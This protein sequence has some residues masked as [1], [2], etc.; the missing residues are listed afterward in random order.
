M[1]EQKVI[2]CKKYSIVFNQSPFQ[3]GFCGNFKNM[4]TVVTRFV[5]RLCNKCAEDDVLPDFRCSID[6]KGKSKHCAVLAGGG[7]F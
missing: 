1:S 3:S 7:A 4:N 6:F 5:V 2:V